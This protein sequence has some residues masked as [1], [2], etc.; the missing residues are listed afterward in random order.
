MNDATATPNPRLFARWFPQGTTRYYVFLAAI[1]VLVLGPLGGVTASYMNFSLGFFVGGQV[2]AG[3]L[4]STITWFYGPEGRHG[5]NYMQTAAASV[6]SMAAMGVLI[7]AM[8]WLGLEEPPVWKLILYFLSVGM[9]GVGVGMIFTPLLVDKLQLTYPSGLAVANI[10]RALTDVRLLRR[11]V[12]QL[13]TGIGIG[14]IV[15]LGLERLGQVE[16]TAEKAAEAAGQKYEP[17]AL[18]KLLSLD[19]SVSTVGAGIILGAR[20]T[21]PAFLYAVVWRELTPWIRANG[22]LGETEPF[23]KFAFLVALGTIMGAAVVDI[24]L[25]LRQA[26]QRIRKAAADKPAPVAEP[27][28]AWKRTNTTRL[29]AWL[30]FWALAVIVVS[31]GLLDVGL[32]WVLFAIVLAFAMMLVNGISFGITDSN[33]IS[34]AFVVSVVLMALVG[35]KAPVEG[36]I[37]A[38]IVFVVTAIGG[39]MQQDRS[40]GWR[41]GTNRTHQFRYQ[42]IGVFLGAVLSVYM[43]KLFMSAYPI[44]KVDGG[45]SGHWQSAMTLKIAGAV[46]SITQPKAFQIPAMLIGVAIGLVTEIVRKVVKGNAR[47]KAWSATRVGFGFDFCFDCF[48]VPSPYASSFAGFVSFATS[49]W[50]SLGGAVSSFVNWYGKKRAPVAK[51]GEPLPEDMSTTSLVGGG[52]IAGDSI[53]AL[54]TGVAGLL[55]LGKGK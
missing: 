41:L 18:A 32:G 47:Y 10:L 7:Q 46:R 34:S 12:G 52:L 53:A 51:E 9:F 27:G 45:G 19:L 33:P 20:V 29:V 5:A 24:A 16:A 44:L 54:A 25:I 35:L 15:P 23:R 22:W 8:V 6:A 50:F 26:V 40:T 55:S 38:S 11:S 39:D 28:E 17:G 1:A 42:V 49:V 21:V 36:L 3:I 4:G 37:A 30:A 43:A 48:L 13:A 31:V 14:T 2:L